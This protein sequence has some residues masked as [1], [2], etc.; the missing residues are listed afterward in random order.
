MTTFLVSGYDYLASVYDQLD[1]LEPDYRHNDYISVYR[2][3]F[4]HLT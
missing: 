1:S 3:V 2:Q 4:N